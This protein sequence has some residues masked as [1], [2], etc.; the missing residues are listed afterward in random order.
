M[1][2]FQW[3]NPDFLFKNPDFLLTN[4]DFLWENVDF[5]IKQAE[6]RPDLKYIKADALMLSAQFGEEVFDAVF[7]KGTLQSLLL[8]RGGIEL[9]QRLAAEI[10]AVLRPGGRLVCV[11]GVQPGLA[12]YLKGP[13]LRWRVSFK[14]VQGDGR[15]ISIYTFTKPIE[16]EGEEPAE[17]EKKV[18]HK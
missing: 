8:M 4:P 18:V 13:G 15:P 10:Y 16:E 2:S 9:S 14:I 5:I 7:D 3:K 12:Q 17:E 1:V 11:V 6:K